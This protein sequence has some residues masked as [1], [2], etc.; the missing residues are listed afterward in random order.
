MSEG[1][2]KAEDKTGLNS[3]DYYFVEDKISNSYYIDKTPVDIHLEYKD[4]K[5]QKSRQ[6]QRNLIRLQKSTCQR[7]S[8]QTVQN[9]QEHHLRLL[10]IKAMKSFHGLAEML[11]Q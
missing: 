1:Y 8:L 11:I 5:T 4:A 7:L 6:R 3:G 10:M 2:N 9:L